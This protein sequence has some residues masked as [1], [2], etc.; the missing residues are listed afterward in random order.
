MPAPEQQGAEATPVTESQG[1]P[2]VLAEAM[3]APE[4]QGAAISVPE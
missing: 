1:E 3:P 2:R 4:Q